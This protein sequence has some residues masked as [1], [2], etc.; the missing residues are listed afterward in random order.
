[1]VVVTQFLIAPAF[2]GLVIVNIL[3]SFTSCCS[4]FLY[5]CLPVKDIDP[6]TLVSSNHRMHSISGKFCVSQN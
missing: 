3:D 2:N 4:Y 5:D 1:M 6:F